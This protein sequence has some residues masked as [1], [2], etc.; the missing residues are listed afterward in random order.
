MLE[1]TNKSISVALLLIVILTG[2]VAGSLTAV[3]QSAP[4]EI[5]V[6]PKQSSLDT[7]E[8]KTVSINY[9]SSSDVNPEGIQFVVEY[10]PDVLTVTSVKG[11]GFGD[12]NTI[13][14]ANDSVPGRIKAGVAK[15]GRITQDTGTLTT[16]TVKLADGVDKGDKTKIKFT[17]VSSDA[18]ESTPVTMD[19]VVEAAE[20]SKKPVQINEQTISN[21]PLE[22]K[23]KNHTLEFDI[24]SVSADNDP[25]NISVK[26]PDQVTVEKIWKTKVTE[27]NTNN[28]VSLP[29]G[30]P[31]DEPV[32]NDIRF[33][34]NPV[35]EVD[36]K[37]LTVKIDMKL[38]AFP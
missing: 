31:A 4:E 8:S 15:G 20:G 25:D 6:D 1:I 30:N 16:I 38:S 17:S 32:S 2:V 13:H 19:G 36:T 35:G 28:E 9:K 12:S 5:Q 21:T 10:N 33:T 14:V 34:V 7:G 37:D 18:V 23:S 22:P 24:S 26:L 27:K 29:D 11:G 3:G